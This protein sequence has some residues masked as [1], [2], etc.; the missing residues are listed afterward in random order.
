MYRLG[1]DQLPLQTR[2]ALGES[3]VRASG[4]RE[5]VCGKACFRH[6]P[7]SGGFRTGLDAIPE[8]GAVDI[9]PG[10]GPQGGP[11]SPEK[12]KALEGHSKAFDAGAKKRT[13][14]STPFRA[15]E[16][17]SSASASS[18]IFARSDLDEPVSSTRDRRFTASFAS[19]ASVLDVPL[20]SRSLG[21]QGDSGVPWLDPP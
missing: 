19:R 16:P 3:P 7:S 9:G 11:R 2:R 14:T 8:L 13:R 10:V 1:P 18:A 15:L 4:L 20:A 6:A 12:A 21:L 17:E 5:K